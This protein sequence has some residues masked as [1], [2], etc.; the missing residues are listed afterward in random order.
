MLNFKFT[1]KFV[2]YCVYSSD[3]S[4]PIVRK[5]EWANSQKSVLVRI[6]GWCEEIFEPD[7]LWESLISY[8]LNACL[9]SLYP[10]NFGPWCTHS[11]YEE[12]LYHFWVPISPAETLFFYFMRLGWAK[13]QHGWSTL[14]CK[15]GRGWKPSF[16]FSAARHTCSVITQQ[17]FMI[18]QPRVMNPNSSHDDTLF[19]WE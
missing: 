15:W 12:S 5:L 9:S 7:C 14:T 4:R 18:S 1:I 11:N 3:S 8:H 6:S 17:C 19:P 16:L 10:P 13:D 2:L